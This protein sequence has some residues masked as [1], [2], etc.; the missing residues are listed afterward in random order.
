MNICLIGNNL[1]SLALAKNLINKKINVTIYHKKKKRIRLKTRTLAISKNNF[2]FLK[3]E[4][5][6]LSSKFFWKVNEIQIYNEKNTNKEILNFNNKN[7]ELFSIIKY[8]EIFDN[9]SKKLIKNKLFKKKII[10]NHFLEKISTD[11]DFDLIINCES[12][13]Y[14]DNKFFYK[15][16]NKDYKSQAY[17]SILKHRPIENKKAVQ[18]FSKFGPI[19]FLPVSQNKTSVVFSIMQSKNILSTEQVK[20]LIKHYNQKY[21]IESFEKLE[22]FKLSSSNLRKYYHKNILAFGDSIHK[23]HPL[24]GQGF[25]MTLR[26]IKI[27]SNIIQNKIDLGLN[28]DESVLEEFQNKIKHLNFLFSNGIDFIYEFFKFDNKFNNNYSNTLSRYF[29]N[30]K[31]INNFLFNIADRGLIV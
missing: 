29:K 13:N 23:I 31:M 12:N 5:I 18:I 22:K 30:N 11:N 24:A 21:K 20:N 3:K 8:D 26:D 16:I 7:K 25:N 19:A 15:R 9:I 14:I 17:T 2:E 1:T 28:L 10:S 27:I 4:I 6:K